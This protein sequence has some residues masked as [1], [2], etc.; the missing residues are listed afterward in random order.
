MILSAKNKNHLK[1]RVFDANGNELKYLIGANT[2]TGEI[3]R[4]VKD[5]HGEFKFDEYGEVIT[6]TVTVPAPLTLTE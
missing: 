4:L 5:N 3:T 6:E 1:Y 2:E